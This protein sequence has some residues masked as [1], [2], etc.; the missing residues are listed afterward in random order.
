MYLIQCIRFG[1]WKVR[2][3]NQALHR[4]V[5]CWSLVYVLLQE[6]LMRQEL[7]F[8]IT[9]LRV[10]FLSAR[11]RRM[12]S[13]YG[14]P[15]LFWTS[16]VYSCFFFI[17]KLLPVI[18]NL[19]RWVCSFMLRTFILVTDILPCFLGWRILLPLLRAFQFS[20]PGISL[21][22][23][24]RVQQIQRKTEPCRRYQGGLWRLLNVVLVLTFESVFKIKNQFMER[25]SI[26]NLLS[27]FFGC[28]KLSVF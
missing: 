7:V 15:I 27:A 16:F 21:F 2:R 26:W 5:N 6:A 13:E 3:L 22:G 14:H 28:L 4:H 1:S 17:R 20:L 9:N 11:S 19:F 10:Y 23:A 12:F 25:Q 8:L 18:A 24:I